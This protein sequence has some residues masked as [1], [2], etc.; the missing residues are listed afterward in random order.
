M[1]AR[2]LF[3]VIALCCAGLVAC[4]G[5]TAPASNAVATLPSAI[6]DPAGALPPAP[7]SAP[8]PAPTPSLD[9]WPRTVETPRASL[10]IYQPQV[11]SWQGNVLRFRVA[12][13]ATPT[14]ATAKSYGVIWGSAATEV[15]RGTRQVALSQ[16]QLTRASFPTAPDGGAA[17]LA[18]LRTQ[19]PSQARTI[20][21]DRLMASLAASGSLASAHVAVQNA[22]PQ[23]LVSSTPAL[24][25]PLDGNPVQRPVSGGGFQRVINTRACLLLEPLSGK[26]FLH[27]Y[28]EIGRA[29]V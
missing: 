4:A 23:I 2:S 12:V 21:L 1:A 10:T 11:E 16:L 14:G 7:A 6:A 28:D 18:A 29:H 15:D 13:A 19:L 26:Y 27:V 20:S 25:I 24:L 3:G 8:A 9:P 22:P 17:Y 5:P